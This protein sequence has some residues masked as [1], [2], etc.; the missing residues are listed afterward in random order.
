MRIYLLI[1]LSNLEKMM[2]IFLDGLNKLD[3]WSVN[4]GIFEEALLSDFKI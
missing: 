2:E 3:T 1:S 4:L